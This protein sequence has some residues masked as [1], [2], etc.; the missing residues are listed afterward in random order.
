MFTIERYCNKCEERLTNSRS[1]RNG[2]MI[3]YRLWISNA[4]SMAVDYSTMLG[5]IRKKKPNK[6]TISK[7]K[8]RQQCKFFGWR[9]RM[10]SDFGFKCSDWVIFG[11][12]AWGREKRALRWKIRIMERKS[13]I[14][15][16]STISKED[17]VKK[18]G[19]NQGQ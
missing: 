10:P 17:K 8:I 19:I 1:K 12:M 2:L 3:F 16:T 14:R 18:E 13:G 7:G 5:P 4:F 6:I 9:R 11:K 15:W